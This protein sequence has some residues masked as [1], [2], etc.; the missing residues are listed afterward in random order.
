MVNTST[1]L[2]G[3]SI[4]KLPF[5]SVWTALFVPFSK[6]VALR[7]GVPSASRTT[8]LTIVSAAFVLLHAYGSLFLFSVDEYQVCLFY[9]I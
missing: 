1:A 7:N 5:A 2:A 3:T 6:T 4:E 9:K 8:P